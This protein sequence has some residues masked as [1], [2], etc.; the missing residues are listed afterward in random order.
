MLIEVIRNDRLLF[1]FLRVLFGEVQ[2]HEQE[3]GLIYT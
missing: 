1:K 2:N 3:Q